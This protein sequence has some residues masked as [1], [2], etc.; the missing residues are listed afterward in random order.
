M[1]LLPDPITKY[2]D[3]FIR[4]APATDNVTIN[5]DDTIPLFANYSDSLLKFASI[6]CIIFALVGI[7]GNL[8]TIIALARCKK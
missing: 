4:I 3:I 8:I 1:D 2:P 7:P 5:T 6:M